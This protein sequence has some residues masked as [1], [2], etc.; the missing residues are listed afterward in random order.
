[1]GRRGGRYFN[2]SVLNGTTPLI[3]NKTLHAGETFTLRVP[4]EQRLPN[5]NSTINFVINS[6]QEDSN[7]YEGAKVAYPAELSSG[8]LYT[9]SQILPSSNV[10]PNDIKITIPVSNDT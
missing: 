8:L 9:N 2:F 10:Y 1:M 7:M 3:T 6:F 5:P 4:I